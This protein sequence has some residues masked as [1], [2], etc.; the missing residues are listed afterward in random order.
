MRTQARLAEGRHEEVL[1]AIGSQNL[2]A[3]D[4]DTVL[5]KL[6]SKLHSH[7]QDDRFE[8]IAQAHQKTFTW[9]LKE[10]T[11]AQSGTDLLN[12][13]QNLSGTYWI[14]GK[15][16]SGK[17]TLMKYLVQD[18]RFKQALQEWAAGDNL[19]VATFYFWRAGAPL[20]RSQT[21]LL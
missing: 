8:D 6:Q 19:V 20:Q 13:L 2:Q 18:D 4:G 16:G 21:G 3:S 11:S 5:Q 17:S 15:A 14:S 1:V 7:R 10:T 12:W 9:A